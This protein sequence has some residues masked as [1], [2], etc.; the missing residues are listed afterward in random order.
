[1]VYIQGM[2]KVLSLPMY[3]RNELEL[4]KMAKH[5]FNEFEGDSFWL[6]NFDPVRVLGRGSNL[7]ICSRKLGLLAYSPRQAFS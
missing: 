1:M 6:K 2:P 5:I 3:L 4:W 7:K